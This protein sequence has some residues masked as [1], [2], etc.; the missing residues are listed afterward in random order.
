MARKLPA[1]SKANVMSAIWTLRGQSG[2]R[3]TWPTAERIANHLRADV[4]DVVPLLRSLR[5]QR[6]FTERQRGGQRVWMPW[7]EA[8]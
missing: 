2:G 8:A 5:S 6:L 3:S 7:D 1:P 4:V